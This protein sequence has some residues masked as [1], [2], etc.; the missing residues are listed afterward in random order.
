MERGIW[1]STSEVDWFGE[2]DPF[3]PS[4]GGETKEDV[5]KHWG[6][7]HIAMN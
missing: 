7:L 2:M 1:I 5:S 3:L 6:K 4:L